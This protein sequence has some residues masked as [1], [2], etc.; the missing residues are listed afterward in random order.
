MANQI[1]EPVVTITLRWIA[2]LISSGV[3]AFLLMFT[4]GEIVKSLISLFSGEGLQEW[5]T[6]GTRMTI[7]ILL[8]G[9][10]AGL[11]WWREGIGGTILAVTALMQTAI[12]F[13]TMDR[14]DHWIS[15]IFSFPFLVS[16]ILFLVC[17]K[18]SRMLRI[19]KQIE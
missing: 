2:R 16:G 8:I 7:Y 11:S 4:I 13:F 1:K 3:A 12:I 17:W 18:R 6:E 9:L 5:N 15:L 19:T 14:S 10:G